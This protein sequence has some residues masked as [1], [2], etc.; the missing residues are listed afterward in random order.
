FILADYSSISSEDDLSFAKRLTIDAGVA[1]IPLSPFYQK[2]SDA[3]ILRFCFAKKEETLVVAA[4]R[5]R[6][7]FE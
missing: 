6:K 7:Y 3:K 1:T 4:E 2:G 5:L